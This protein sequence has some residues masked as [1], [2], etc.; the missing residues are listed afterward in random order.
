M[1][2]NFIDEKQM[3]SS[4]ADEIFPLMLHSNSSSQ[5]L[6]SQNGKS[7]VLAPIC[8]VLGL[9]ECCVESFMNTAEEEAIWSKRTTTTTEEDKDSS[10]LE[11]E[12]RKQP[13]YYIRRSLYLASND[14]AHEASFIQPLRLSLLDSFITYAWLVFLFCAFG[15]IHLQYLNSSEHLI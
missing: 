1:L 15:R 5:L 11:A 4:F 10:R 7:D 3:L 13:Q 12:C 9:A 6:P 2:W 8:T 14:S